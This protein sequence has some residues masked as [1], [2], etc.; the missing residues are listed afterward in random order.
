MESRKLSNPPVAARKPIVVTR[1]TGYSRPSANNLPAVSQQKPA[2]KDRLTIKRA[3]SIQKPAEEKKPPIQRN[4]SLNVSA[5]SG[6]TL[7]EARRI[8][9]ELEA[10]NQTKKTHLESLLEKGRNMA[11]TKKSYE[12]EQENLLK[13]FKKMEETAKEL[14]KKSEN[15]MAEINGL[16]AKEKELDKKWKELRR[17]FFTRKEQG[18]VRA[19]QCACSANRIR[20]GGLHERLQ[21]TLGPAC[22]IAACPRT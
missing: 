12:G 16:L 18:R 6:Q 4:A 1:P 7:E 8:V 5:P 15:T 10:E 9:A 11:I 2:D 20:Y 13:E 14:T 22:L 21:V 3:G 17:I 19:A